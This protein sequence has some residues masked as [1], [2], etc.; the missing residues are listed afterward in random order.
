MPKRVSGG[1]GREQDLGNRDDHYPVRELGTPPRGQPDATTLTAG[2]ILLIADNQARGGPAIEFVD[3]L[4]I[5]DIRP[6]LQTALLSIVKELLLNACLHSKS[7]NVLLGL[8]QDDGCVCVQVQDWGIG[9]DPEDIP[10]HRVGLQRGLQG[11]RQLV[12]RLGGTV[13]IESQPRTGTCVLVEI[14][15]EEKTEPNEPA[16]GR[17]PK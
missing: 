15:L 14:P 7:E 11:V 16:R 6:E 5:V 12:G 17:R 13:D 3:D 9:F 1:E 10:P 4:A 2:V 8:G